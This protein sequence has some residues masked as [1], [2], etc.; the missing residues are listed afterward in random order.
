M[1]HGK[2]SAVRVLKVLL[3]WTLLLAAIMA[4]LADVA[5][6]GIHDH[7]TVPSANG[8]DLTRDG[9]DPARN[10]HCEFWM[11]PGALLVVAAPAPLDLL[12]T[13]DAP[14]ASPRKSQTLSVPVSPP[15]S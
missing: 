1:C 7:I 5:A 15:R 4:P 6:F 14:P 2:L 8:G 12:E 13:L 3:A 11:S 10:H 9:S